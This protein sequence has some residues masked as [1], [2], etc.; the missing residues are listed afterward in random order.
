MKIILSVIAVCL[1]MITV[2]MYTPRVK[3]DIYSIVGGV[4]RGSEGLQLRNYL[5]D[6]YAQE[7]HNHNPVVE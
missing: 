4:V 1:V 6:Y 2:E 7:N 3:A 5:D